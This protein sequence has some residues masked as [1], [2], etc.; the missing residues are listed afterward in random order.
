MPK[1]RK[2][3]FDPLPWL[4]IAGATI[5]CATAAA[6]PLTTISSL[7][8]GSYDS[9]PLTNVNTTTPLVMLALS[10]DHQLHY[11][12]YND[13][14]DLDG[15][16]TPET[17]YKGNLGGS[18]SFVGYYGYFDPKK[19][20]TYANGIFSP[21]TMAT[22]GADT[23][24][25]P[26]AASGTVP[27]CSSAWSGN[28]LNWASMTR[29]DAIRKLLYGGK[30][31]T[32]SATQTILERDY[33]P[34]D[35]HAFAKYYNG[36]DISKLTP[37]SD[38]ANT[39][40]AISNVSGAISNSAYGVITNTKVTQNGGS[41]TVT[42]T[43]ANSFIAGES[44]L[45]SGTTISDW[46]G[47]RTVTAASA[48]SYSFATNTN[49]S[50]RSTAAIPTTA[51]LNVT[52]I[53]QPRNSKVV[54]VN[55]AA[56]PAVAFT[57]GQKVTLASTGDATWDGQRTITGVSNGSQTFTFSTAS[58]TCNTSASCA[59]S[60]GA[61]GTLTY[62][63]N[64]AAN[65]MSTGKS[66][67]L[68]PVAAS[69]TAPVSIGDQLKIVLDSSN[70]MNVVVTALVD[71]TGTSISGASSGT[72]Y[73][74]MTSE[75]NGTTPFVSVAG[76]G[77]STSLTVT[78]L[79]TSGISFCNL[80]VGST[81][82]MDVNLLSQTNTNAP[83]L[84]V[85]RG[86]YTVWG[87]NERYQCH[88]LGETSDQQGRFAGGLRSNGNRA[89]F[90]GLNGGAENPV[91]TLVGLGTGSGTGEFQVRVAA[92]VNGLEGAERC[93]TYP[94][95]NGTYASGVE[96]PIG[97]LQ[98][99]GETGRIN[100]GLM[101][102]SYQKNISGG[103]LRKNTG[104]L[105]DE[106]NIST[107][108]TFISAATG[109]IGNIDKLRIYGYNY[110]DGGYYT[111][112]GDNCT[113]QL[114]GLTPSG[115]SNTQGSLQNE[116]NCTSW[117]NPIG[118]VYTEALRY[119][120]G[121]TPDSRFTYSSG[122]KDATL[123]LTAIN[124]WTDPLAA[125]NKNYCASL[126]VLLFNA[127][128]SSYDDDQMDKLSDLAG[129]PSAVT[130]TNNVGADEGISGNYF[131]G[132][133]GTINNTT[134]DAKS[135]TNLGNVTGI[136]PEAPGLKGTYLLDGAAFYAHTHP[137]RSDLTVPSGDTTSLKVDTYGIQLATN[138][139]RIVIP[140][141]SDSS[142]TLAT[143]LPVYR[144]DVPNKSPPYGG[145][146]IVDFRIVSQDVANGTGSFYI[147][148]ED[149]AQ[150][151][152]YDQDMWGTINYR[153]NGNN[154]IT[155]TTDAIANSTAN[156]QGFG[157]IISGTTQDGPHFHS[158]ILNFTYND[159]SG[160]AS[161]PTNI[162]VK[163]SAGNTLNGQTFNGRS[164]GI[165]A[166]GG[167][168]G[169][170]VDDPATSVTYTLSKSGSAS[171][172]QD[173]LYY[174][175]KYGGFIDD[176]GAAGAAPDGTPANSDSTNR[177]WDSH[178]ADGSLGSDGQPDNYFFVSNPGALEQSLG[179]ALNAIVARAA[180]GTAS[181]V[182]AN[183]RQGEG[184]IYQ[185]LY[186]PA[187]NDSQNRKVNWIGTL[188]ALFID[189]AGNLREDGNGDAKLEESDLSTDPIVRISFDT[190]DRQTE[191]F[192]TN[193]STSNVKD[194]L[195]N[196]KPLWTART[197]LS[198]LTDPENQRGYT[199]AVTKANDGSGGYSGGRYIFTFRDH[200]LGAIPDNGVPDG[201]SDVVAF[202]PSNFGAG[203][204]G[205]LN[206]N[207]TNDAT[208][209]V[210][211]IRGKES[212]SLR[213]RTID[214]DNDGK[215]EVMRLGDIVNSSPITVAAPAEAFN[216]LYGD[217]S[218]DTFFKKYRQRRNVVYVGANDGMI[219]AFNAGFYDAATLSFKLSGTN[220]ETSHPLGT[221]LWAYI[222][223]NLLPHLAWLSDPSY[224]HVWYNDGSPRVFDARIFANDADHPGGWGTVLVMGMRLGGGPISLPVNASTS[225]GFSQ[226]S[227]LSVGSTLTARSAYSILD[228]TNP[229][230][231][232][233]VIAELT[234]GGG[235]LGF[236]TG[237]P[238][239]A[240]FKPSDSSTPEKWYLIFGSGPN[241]ASVRTALDNAGSS[242]NAQLFIY[243]LSA[244]SYV[245][246]YGPLDLSSAPNS[247]LGSP[248][249]VDWDL[250]FKADVL[251]FGTSGS[252][253]AAPNGKL[254]RLDFHQTAAGQ[255]DTLN[256]E[257]SAPGDWISP[258]VLVDPG[259]PVLALPSVTEDAFG[260]KWVLSGTGRFIATPDKSSTPQQFLFGAIDDLPK[261]SVTGAARF[262]NLLDVSSAIVT[263][264]KGDV[265]VSGVGG[266]TTELKLEQLVRDDGGWK[267]NLS[268]ASTAAERSVSNT[269][270]LA[271][272]F[273]AS[274]YTPAT[275]L[276]A[277]DG[278]TRLFGL[279]FETGAAL[280]D[281]A[282]LGTLN[283]TNAN[284]STSTIAIGVLELGAGLGTAPTI[285]VDNNTGTGGNGMLTI[286]VQ[287]SN[288]AIIQT[289]ATT[290]GGDRSGEI[291]WRETHPSNGP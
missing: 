245:S 255:A 283:Q 186:S 146:A 180:S 11:K 169:C 15:D 4:L 268:T 81:A 56:A 117:G 130:W 161:D 120:A 59:K 193:G 88:W 227:S 41:S 111:G 125:A 236:S 174:A 256:S 222:P 200:S 162:T 148:W 246:G 258:T 274:T 205:V 51:A 68:L 54:T 218:Y 69:T 152:D 9:F 64:A 101:T 270:V 179:A 109:I 235:K 159:S 2:A 140:N 8:E 257:S 26:N 84:R 219:H 131:V 138:V 196:L 127:S 66:Q 55:L 71:S 122:S 86:N 99:Y 249:A 137:I 202:L 220:S 172:L 107:D 153:V 93:E 231:P 123:G 83:L 47:V 185:A 238:T 224:S 63:Y 35:A 167:C 46:D 279:N 178:K 94:T 141:P 248:V 223:F 198:K 184:A 261:S 177:E 102:P 240:A 221:E 70:A 23:S 155:V 288:G 52:S 286:N 37:F 225:A 77:S 112:N 18:G 206:V 82:S 280:P 80:T 151:G 53:S 230:K 72:V 13:Y 60:S 242:Q 49:G 278:D 197:V 247:F 284:G 207:S 25:L 61:I 62:T 121:K 228:I 175:A 289:Q 129:S 287:T 211:Y 34:T 16:G 100:F 108:G 10:R 29:M 42:V 3:L 232:P 216:L 281:P 243:D 239:V 20:Y 176:K 27:Y 142:K 106:I 114:L 73:V 213:N 212:S 285:H 214:F 110:A 203:E 262:T 166:S 104:T 204:Y 31:S 30:R 208:T 164:P 38:I 291:D 251:Y 22:F 160:A 132:N 165:S 158:G 189:K 96:K 95:K 209:L 136:C 5:A 43:V 67:L 92:C 74:Q 254:F 266:A 44:V 50:T 143:L 154:T 181:S 194:S 115:G 79:S 187:R 14:S 103:V 85:A 149:S 168:V 118:E 39:P 6:G 264:G 237:T 89:P 271:Q 253:A 226:Y 32:D 150:G 147:N 201:G 267:L 190:T 139:P 19:C 173:P 24:G 263:A 113:F 75:S 1:L 277:G 275:T 133:N 91:Q 98:V 191:V 105:S 156:G 76:S 199:T 233:T 250:N 40:S 28:F 290:A 134:C 170:T 171:S 78:D 135:I 259:A 58:A 195:D 241:N 7:V 45:V 119:F 273:F 215:T 65:V 252:T 229:E 182:V 188:Q 276:C 126:N 192:R 48:S 234:D 183:S 260:H 272:I 145:G 90:S 217:K 244:K 21:S 157:Y 210:N 12:A 128:V 269:S 116:G 36:A 163:D 33:L 144:L 17:T 265:P 57:V 87:A 124:A 97:L 282:P